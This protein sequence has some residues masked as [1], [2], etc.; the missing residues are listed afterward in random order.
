MRKAYVERKTLETD[1]KL[2]IQLDGDGIM[3]G[4]S[5][6]GFLDHMLVLFSKHGGLS[7]NL[8]AY[9]DTQVDGHHTVEDIGLCLGEAYYEALG[10][11]VG[12]SR[13]ASLVLPMDEALVLCAV[14]ISGRPGLYYE[15][16]FQSEKIG[17]FDTEL[18][19]V[20]WQAFANTAKMTIHIRQLAGENS[21]HVAEAVF[22]GMGRILKSAVRIDSEEL[23]SSKGVL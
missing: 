4:N 22:K 9:G 19:Q 2:N 7:L 8:E 20:F 12:I 5:Q 15:V 6:I 18:I 16:N 23:P 11:K 14:D 3:Q 21:H 13:Y 17:E 1:I 10:D